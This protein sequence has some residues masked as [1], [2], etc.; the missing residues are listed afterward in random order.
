MNSLVLA[1][2]LSLSVTFVLFDS[3]SSVRAGAIRLDPLHAQPDS[4]PAITPKP[5]PAPAGTKPSQPVAPPNSTTPAPPPLA[6][7]P[8]SSPPAPDPSPKPPA[9]DPGL[10][11]LD[12]LLGTGDATKPGDTPVDPLDPNAIDLD[13][14][15]S[16]AEIGDAFKQAVT[17]MG[18]A[19][20]R[21]KDG[22]DASLTTQRVQESIVR[23][24]DQLLSSIE[25]QQQ[26]QQSSSSS[27][28]PQQQQTPQNVPQQQQQDQPKQENQGDNKGNQSQPPGRRDAQIRPGLEAARSSWG[29]LP[30][31]VRDLLVQGSSDRFSSMYESMTEA[32][33]KK[34]AQQGKP[35]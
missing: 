28:Q 16:G 4:K 13:R 30:D 5:Q 11:S 29:Q 23:R 21:L 35:R 19:S 25:Q 31:R 15:L 7:T 18:D 1:A 27:Q 9:N 2:F 24:L 10:P 8:P 33:Y 12:D 32:Y 34:L 20:K 17:L 14:L 6:P 26:Q 3:S 22:K